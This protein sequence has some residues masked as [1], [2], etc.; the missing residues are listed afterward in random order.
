MR[1]ALVA[2]RILSGGGKKRGVTA[3]SDLSVVDANR[4]EIFGEAFVEPCLRGGIVV[5][6]QHAGEIFRDGTPGFLFR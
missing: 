3:E 5:I 4:S 2:E 6:Q 1:V